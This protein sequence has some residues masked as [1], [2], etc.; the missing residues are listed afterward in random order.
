MK[1]RTVLDDALGR[2]PKAAAGDWDGW[3]WGE[4]PLDFEDDDGVGFHV[5][6]SLAGALAATSISESRAY[7][8]D[9]AIRICVNF[10]A[11][12][13]A[14]TRLKTYDRRSDTERVEVADH[15]LA[16]LL[17]R[18]ND[19]TSGF[20]LILGLVSDLALYDEAYWLKAFPRGATSRPDRLFRLPP[21]YVEPVGGDIF[22]GPD[23]YELRRP[24]GG[25]V[26]ARFDPERIVH[27]RWYS[28]NDTRVGVS[29]LKALRST[30]DEER[31]AS[32]HRFWY[33]RNAGRFEGVLERPSDAAPWDDQRRKR[34]REDW[35][36][37][38][39][40]GR[41][42]G[43]PQVAE[44]GMKYV[45]AGFSP[46]DSE[47]IAG[48]EWALNIAA[49]TFGIPLAM[50]SRNDSQAYA[51]MRE[52]HK[53]LY[54]DVLGPWNAFIEDTIGTQLVP[55]LEAEDE[56][57]YVEFNIAEKMQGDFE[58]QANAARSVVQVPSMSVDDFRAKQNLP[59]LGPPY[60][61]P[62]KPAN[63][64]YEGEEPEEEEETEN[65]VRIAETA[66]ADGGA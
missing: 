27:F 30:L 64:L 22:L 58:E 16:R 47:F 59:P 42:A 8:L 63:Y 65:V 45:Q 17:R 32:F 1:L 61:K 2:S 9:V 6:S 34:F 31:Q 18:P 51:S 14:H 46:R 33:W 24:D 62:A 37:R 13:I 11:T 15:R 55:D 44:D 7:E 39:A 5:S 4:G 53:V 23:R 21:T 66:R 35:A 20:D 49:T 52:F 40:G 56:D 57:L 12:N 19:R 10:L 54:T 26:A 48:R 36:S 38:Y 50:L 41:N 43:V 25:V 60:D 28:P 3:P 29:R